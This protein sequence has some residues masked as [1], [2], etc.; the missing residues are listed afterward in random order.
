MSQYLR[1]QLAPVTELPD[2]ELPSRSLEDFDHSQTLILGHSGLTRIVYE[3]GT[4]RPHIIQFCQKDITEQRLLLAQI[5]RDD[6][7]FI[8]MH[9]TFVYRDNIYIGSKV[10]DVCLADIIDCTVPLTEVH[11]SSILRRVK[12]YCTMAWVFTKTWDRLFKL[13]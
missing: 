10:A 11:A 13:W 5:A 2:E 1:P 9:F 7:L 12:L 6:D 8:T 3:R 4:F